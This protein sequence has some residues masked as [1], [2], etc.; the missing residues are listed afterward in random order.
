MFTK[1]AKYYL[2]KGLNVIITNNVK[3]SLFK[4]D[5]YKTDM[6]TLEE[7]EQQAAHKKAGGM[8]VVCGAVSGGLEVID[9][10][11]KYAIDPDFYTKFT[12]AIGEDIMQ[13][14]YI[15]QTK[16]GGYHFYYRCEVIEG[17][18]KLCHRYKTEA[19]LK[20]NPSGKKVCLI[21][22][23]GEGGYVIAPPTDGYNVIGKSRDIHTLTI[24]EREAIFSA[25]MSLNE[26]IE[27]KHIDY[28][29]NPKMRDFGLS[30]F[31]AYNKSGDI[32]RLLTRHGWQVVEER[33]AKIYFL[34]PGNTTAKSSGNFDRDKNW[35]SV[36]TTNSI[37]EPEKAYQPSAVYTILE[38]GGDF[39]K[40]AKM[41][42]DEGYGEKRVSYGNKIETEVFKR[43]REGQTDKQIAEWLIRKENKDIEEAEKIVK[44]VSDQMGEIICA[45]W[46]IN[47]KGHVNIVR[48]KLI[49][50]IMNEGGFSLYFHN[51]SKV[52]QTVRIVDGI[53][54][55]TTT[56]QLKKFIK[57]YILNLPAVFDN[58]ITPDQLLEMVMKG[59]N[60]YFCSALLEFV[61]ERK[62]DFLKDEATKAYYP[63]RNGVVVVEKGKPPV[64]KTYGDINKHVW[65]NQVIDFDITI[66]PEIDAELIEYARFL[67]NISG[68]EQDRFEY[69]LTLIGY[70]LHGFKNPSRPFAP[71]LAEET[72]DEKKGGG[73]G[74]GLFIKAIGKLIPLVTIDGKN[75]KID[76]TFAFQRVS[77]DTR[78]V[79]IE[80]C[81][82]N[83]DFEKFYPTITEGITIEKKNKDEIFLPYAESPKIAFTTN[84]TISQDAEH[85]KR[86]QRIFEF[87]SHYSSAYTPEDEFGHKFFDDWDR[88]EWNR[89]YNLLFQCVGMYLDVGIKQVGNSDKMK[90]KHI[91]LAFGE[92]FLDYFDDL[93]SNPSGWL[94]LTKEHTNFLVSNNFEKKD[95]SIKRFRKALQEASNVLQHNLTFQRNRQLNNVQQF[96]IGQNVR[97][98]GGDVRVL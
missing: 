53:V 7:V 82:R 6:I 78:L 77:F 59:A 68:K 61:D 73:T 16:S 39:S 91:K 17:N 19:E 64:L 48:S 35:F 4:W 55:E 1:A 34:R 38:A 22:T 79:V 3:Q 60:I 76:K 28:R 36:F 70:M 93:V 9:I 45:F 97:D 2:S 69:A 26:V 52:F 27:E 98:L 18:Q 14:L 47:D 10:D 85:A 84:Y 40:A 63:F 31:E 87:A 23:R 49:D 33:G 88:D 44:H 13:R 24:A 37:F 83:V 58:G 41:L 25:A 67:Y 12:E 56:E 62:L 72:D 74:K 92:E 89:F 51:N 50:F 32:V 8:A 21:E 65:R 11:L 15:V 75:F 57:D 30:P 5:K 54:E 29:H 95:Y 90:R 96:K 86:R 71:I 81:P 42:L 20:E 80:D 94:E 66:D 43:R 46:E